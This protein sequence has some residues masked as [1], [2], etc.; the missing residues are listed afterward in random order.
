MYISLILKLKSPVATSLS[1][2]VIGVQ[3][4]R[5]GV[6][7]SIKNKMSSKLHSKL[8]RMRGGKITLQ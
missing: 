6:N 8:Q 3:I 1:A 4:S 2:R 5:H 7:Q